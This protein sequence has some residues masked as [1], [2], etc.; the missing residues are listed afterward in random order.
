MNESVAEISQREA[1]ARVSVNQ[2]EQVVRVLNSQIAAQ[3]AKLVVSCDELR[4]MLATVVDCEIKDAVLGR[5]ADVA[6]L[7][8]GQHVDM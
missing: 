8:H 5:L 3:E 4:A 7:L 1:A 2:N 6:A